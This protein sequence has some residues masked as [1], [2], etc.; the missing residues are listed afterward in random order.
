[1]SAGN[2]DSSLLTFNLGIELGQALVILALFPTL[3]WCVGA[4]R[5]PRPPMPWRRR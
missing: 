5:G 3:T 1:M 2:A 4:S